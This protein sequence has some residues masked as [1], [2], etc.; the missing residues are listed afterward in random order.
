MSR[1]RHRRSRP[2]EDFETRLRREPELSIR[3][4][5]Q[6]AWSSLSP[7]VA[8]EHAARLAT[9]EAVAR[10]E[11]TPSEQRRHFQLFQ[12]MTSPERC[13]TAIDVY[14]ATFGE[15][16]EATMRKVRA[17]VPPP[18]RIPS[19]WSG[20]TRDPRRAAPWS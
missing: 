6:L 10:S 8:D 3:I 20:R 1:K 12:A 4:L 9:L 13:Q 16:P 11:L 2:P 14:E 5:G 17:L 7:D 18:T 15:T 19:H